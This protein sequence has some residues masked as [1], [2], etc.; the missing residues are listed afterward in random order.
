MSNPPRASTSLYFDHS[1][2]TS[3]TSRPSSL[4][5][6][7]STALKIGA[8]QVMPIYPTRTLVSP[9]GEGAVSAVF[10]HPPNNRAHPSATIP[11]HFAFVIF[12]L[13]VIKIHL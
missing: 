5:K 4:K 13:E 1:H 11:S 6:P 7:F 9:P 8:S 2:F 10:L 12:E 3:S